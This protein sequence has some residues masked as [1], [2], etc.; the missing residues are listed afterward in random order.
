VAS[1]NKLCSSANTALVQT[2]YCRSAVITSFL[3]WVFQSSSRHTRPAFLRIWDDYFQ[4]K[5]TTTGKQTYLQHY[6]E[7]RNLVPK[8][9]LLEYQVQQGW[10]PLCKFL[11][12]PIPHA[13]FPEGNDKEETTRRIKELV[14]YEMDKAAEKLLWLLGVVYIS[15]IL[16][17][18]LAKLA[19]HHRIFTKVRRVF[20][21]LG[22][23][24]TRQILP[25]GF[26]IGP[27][28]SV[29]IGESVVAR[30]DDMGAMEFSAR[31]F[32]HY[33]LFDVLN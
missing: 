33:G 25:R 13:A 17:S 1:A 18:P 32:D 10:E 21:I 23:L 27:N 31:N 4:G 29:F 2:L 11:D 20:R 30:F 28:E 16:F 5:F 9:R 15:I 19:R 12:V 7:V 22:T 6:D 24:P 14:Q 8:G 3:A 26:G